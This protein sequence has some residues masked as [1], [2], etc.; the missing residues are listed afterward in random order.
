MNTYQTIFHATC[1]SD[2]ERIKYE[3]TLESSQTV[4]VESINKATAK[5]SSG[6]QE[7]IAQALHRQ[8]SCCVVTLKAVHQGVRITTV[9][10]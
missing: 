3:L 9:L 4:M 7:D 1:P 8:F 5:I 6:Y 2:G 10:P